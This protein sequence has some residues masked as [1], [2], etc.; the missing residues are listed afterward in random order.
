MGNAV[1]A[2]L[3]NQLLARETQLAQIGGNLGKSHPQYLS[4][5]SEIASLRKQLDAETRRITTSFSTS[6]SVG[7]DR[8]SDLRAA[9]AAQKK[10]L[11]ELRSE[12]DQ[13]AV[14]QRDVDAAQSAYD[15]V[16][17]RFNQTSLESQITQANVSVLNPAIEPLLPS[18][19]NVPRNMAM[20]VIAGILLGC[21]AAFLLELLDRRIRSA[22]DLA[23]M[24]QL[25]VLAVIEHP[26]QRRLAFW[27]RPAL[28]APR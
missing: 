8:E 27:R 21:G 9:I 23:E 20:A 15:G 11:L 24:L 17:K 25:P 28:P 12:R 4:M 13:L 7:K 16:T 1:I 26:R 22:E 10:Q 3:R 19:P 6:R 2:G 5:E 18:S 14:L